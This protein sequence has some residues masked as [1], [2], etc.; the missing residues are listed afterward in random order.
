VIY[1]MIAIAL[2]LPT[3]LS[4]RGQLV[5]AVILF[6]GLGGL[7][8]FAMYDMSRQDYQG[9]SGSALGLAILVLFFLMLVAGLLLGAVLRMLVVRAHRRWWRPRQPGPSPDC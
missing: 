9:S 2:G 8:A 1:W 7:I 3:L 6:F 4:P 5:Y